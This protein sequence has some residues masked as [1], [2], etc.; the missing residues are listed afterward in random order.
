M[1]TNNNMQVVKNSSNLQDVQVVDNT[2]TKSKGTSNVN[3]EE[4]TANSL[5]VETFEPI[6]RK[7]FYSKLRE[8]CGLENFD[9]CEIVTDIAKLLANGEITPQQFFDMMNGK[10]KEVREKNEKANNSPFFLLRFFRLI[11]DLFSN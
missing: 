1:T 3:S 6:A 7:E 11:S 4:E 9:K 2:T 5:D 8:L 10:S